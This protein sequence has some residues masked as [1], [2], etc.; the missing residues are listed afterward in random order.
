MALFA[1]IVLF[2]KV[3]LVLFWGGR[4]F[5]RWQD[6]INPHAALSKDTQK[7]MGVRGHLESFW[8]TSADAAG[9]GCVLRAV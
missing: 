8:T 5:L 6:H 3:E 9:Q 4:G 7:F 1:I 2:S